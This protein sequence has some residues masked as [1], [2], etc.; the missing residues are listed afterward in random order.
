M[1]ELIL[2]RFYGIVHEHGDGQKAYAAGYGRYGA[3]YFFGVFKVH[4]ADEL[5]GSDAVDADVDDG[6]ARL[7]HVSGDEVRPADC[8]YEDVSRA[9]DFLE[10]ARVRMADGDSGVL[11]EQELCHGLAD[12]IAA[13][14]D[15]GVRSVDGNMSFLEHFEAAVRRA[16]YHALLAQHQLADVERME[17][18]HVFERADVVENVFFIGGQSVRQRQLEQE[19]VYLRA[20]IQFVD[21][22]DELF[23][24]GVFRHADDF[25]IDAELFTGAVLVAHVDLRGGIFAHDDDGEPRSNAILFL[26]Q[27]DISFCFFFKFSGVYFAG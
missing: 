8:R 20:E 6:C 9:A 1:L 3:G 26:D 4:V 5:F 22:G 7:D 10:V 16:G 12:D 25:G 11:A 23:F 27:I 14:D 15:D 18:V 19:A 24:R 13:A 21:L 17:A 2:R